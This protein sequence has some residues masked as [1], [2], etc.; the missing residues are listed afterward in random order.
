VLAA[1]HLIDRLDRTEPRSP[2]ALGSSRALL[3]SVPLVVLATTETLEALLSLNTHDAVSCCAVVYDAVKRTTLGVDIDNARWVWLTALGGLLYIALGVGLWRGSAQWS[4]RLS[5]AAA[6]VSVVWVPGA[7]VAMVRTFASYHYEVLH[8]YCPWC[9]FL[10]EH[11]CVGF[12]TFGALAWAALEGL[13]AWLALATAARAPAVAE[14][15]EARARTAGW[16]LALA[17]MVYGLVAAA[18]AVVYR[19]R[20]GTWLDGTV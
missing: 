1:W 18:P 17:V 4:R 5:P 12:L 14:A 9:L 7:T 16:R 8:H 10:P 6:L 2:L 20:F 15:A 19:L 13:A 3:L 11:G